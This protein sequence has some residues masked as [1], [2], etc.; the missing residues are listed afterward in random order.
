MPSKALRAFSE[1]ACGG[2]LVRNFLADRHAACHAAGLAHN[3]IRLQ[4]DA[5]WSGTSLAGH[6]LKEQLSSET[7]ERFGGLINDGE[8]GR[9]KL[10]AFHLR[11]IAVASAGHAAKWRKFREEYASDLRIDPERLLEP[12]VL[13][14]AYEGSICPMLGIARRMGWSLRRYECRVAWLAVRN[15]GRVIRRV[16]RR[17]E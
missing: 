8:K 16:T 1:A 17:R 4:D 3:Q 6:P 7:A 10:A 12:N 15:P 2:V 11:A 5:P 13:A 9:Q 14:D